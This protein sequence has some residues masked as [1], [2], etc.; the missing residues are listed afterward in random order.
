LPALSNSPVGE[1]RSR[2]LVLTA[3]LVIGFALNQPTQSAVMPE[4]VGIK[5]VPYG[6]SL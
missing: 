4:L 5:N 2:L 1:R 6:V 3:L